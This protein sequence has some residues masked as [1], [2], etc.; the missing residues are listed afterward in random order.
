MKTIV[1]RYQGTYWQANNFEISSPSPSIIPISQWIH[2]AASIQA[3][4]SKLI[5]NLFQIFCLLNHVIVLVVFVVV[6][7][8][9]WK[10]QIC[11]KHHCIELW[12]YKKIIKNA[13]SAISIFVVNI[14]FYY[15]YSFTTVFS[16][17]R[18]IYVSNS[19]ASFSYFKEI[20]V[21]FVIVKAET[22]WCIMHTPAAHDDY[23]V[24]PYVVLYR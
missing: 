2:F 4:K 13:L 6:V 19:K 11:W 5:N 16:I 1:F 17:S 8:L 7:Q 14:I 9:L 24:T 18:L 23:T 3:I 21:D 20:F 10:C 15:N 22:T 12:I